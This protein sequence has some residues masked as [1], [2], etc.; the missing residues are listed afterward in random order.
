MAFSTTTKDAYQTFVRAWS[1]EWKISDLDGATY[2]FIRLYSRNPESY[3][4]MDGW[5]VPTE[6]VSNTMLE[7]MATAENIQN[8]EPDCKSFDWDE[9]LSDTF[10]S[11]YSSYPEM[12][13]NLRWYNYSNPWLLAMDYTGYDYAGA[14]IPVAPPLSP[15]ADFVAMSPKVNGP[16]AFTAQG[17]LSSRPWNAET[18]AQL[19]DGA[20]SMG[21]KFYSY[22]LGGRL[23]DERRGAAPDD[24]VEVGAA[25]DALSHGVLLTVTDAPA[26]DEAANNAS[27]A[28]SR[29]LDTLTVS[30]QPSRYYNFLNCY[31]I[32][33][34][35]LFRL[36]YGDDVSVKLVDIKSRADPE[37]RLKTWC[38][39]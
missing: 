33:E 37:S 19:W 35:E 36:Y 11:Y 27:L 6:E 12:Q 15:Y 24:S 22:A 8:G 17:I 20:L 34:P 39:I 38:D 23:D 28:V 7:G 32:S 2:P 18:A 30:K 16:N 14:D 21:F 29:V 9:F 3:I 13:D 5:D 4:V 31:N 26:A 25:F 1:D 10:G